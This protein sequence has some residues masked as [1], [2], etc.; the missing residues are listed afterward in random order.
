MKALLGSI[1]FL[2]SLVMACNAVCTYE[3][4]NGIS[5]DG[6]VDANGKKY[7]LNFQWKKDCKKCVCDSN[8]ISCCTEYPVPVGYD[9][10]K[11][12]EKF[13]SKKCT[14]RVVEKKNPRKSCKVK[15]WTL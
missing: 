3:L 1:L 9:I 10:R 6:C 12:Q 8:G 2:A 15:S 7:P 5:D 14:Y 11:C 13:D 4:N